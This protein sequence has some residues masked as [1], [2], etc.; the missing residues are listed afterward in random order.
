MIE[1][2]KETNMKN[3]KISIIAA[4]A[5]LVVC[6]GA[7]VGSTLA[8]F[9][10]KAENTGNIIAS[11]T[12][13]IDLQKYDGTTYV[14]IDGK[15]N[16]LFEQKP[17][18]PNDYQIAF[19]KVSNLGNLPVE[20]TVDVR[21][22]DEDGNEQAGLSDAFE[23][24]I[25]M[26]TMGYENTLSTWKEFSEYSGLIAG[27]QKVPY[28]FSTTEGTP[29]Q[30]ENDQSGKPLLSLDPFIEGT[31]SNFEDS[32][33]LGIHMLPDVGN[34]YQGQTIK[35]DLTIR[36]KQSGENSEDA[37]YPEPSV[38]DVY[39]S[40]NSAESG[41]DVNLILDD[42]MTLT[43][44]LTKPN[45]N[46]KNITITGNGAD[47]KTSGS[48]FTYENSSSGSLVIDGV[49]FSNDGG[50]QTTNLIS[51][52]LQS[53]VNLTLRNCTFTGSN[54]NN[55][56]WLSSVPDGN[57]TKVLIE[58]CTF[59]RPIGIHCDGASD[60]CH[61]P[62]VTI[63]NCEFNIESVEGYDN[64]PIVMAGYV[65]NGSSFTGNTYNTPNFITYYGNSKAM[66]EINSEWNKFDLTIS[67]NTTTATGAS[68]VTYNYSI[69]S[70]A[71]AN[72][73]QVWENAVAAGQIK[74]A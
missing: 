23:Y 67:G 3:R 7:L 72:P 71:A 8:W 54:Y 43:Q 6:T 63:R 60:S 53:N 29:L 48:A 44:G 1:G 9:T 35:I 2:K 22:T 10:D 59:S 34:E 17:W 15:E 74:I 12:V 39:D 50:A 58:N 45:L 33:A 25:A 19:L 55:A 14:S 68:L 38:E 31:E 64:T 27:I 61:I 16:S 21:V 46:G 24:G 30:N 41:E 13:D 47:F 73:Q 28:G 40:I 18:M 52:A 66:E 37:T 69:S 62:N 5:S 20:Y 11:G 65:N 57:N 4:A 70:G 32:F 56:V 26:N 49:D 36:A 51:I 42:S